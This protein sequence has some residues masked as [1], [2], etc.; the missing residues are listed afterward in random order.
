[1][2]KISNLLTFIST[3][4]L[5]LYSHNINAQEGNYNFEQYGNQSSLLSGNVI[6]GVS[7]LAI[8]YYN[9]S[10]LVFNTQYN[11]LI[12]VKAYELNNFDYKYVF[13]GDRSAS[14]SQFRG[15]PSIVVGNFKFKSLPNHSFAYSFLSRHRSDL[16]LSFST[17]VLDSDVTSDIEGFEQVALDLD[18]SD[19]LTEEWIGLTWAHQPSK[20][21]S[22]GASAFLSIYNLRSSGDFLFSGLQSNDD[23]LV[24]TEKIR[25]KQQTYGLFFKLGATWVN[26]NLKI[27][28]TITLPHI[29]VIKKAEISTQGFFSGSINDSGEITQLSDDDIE[30]KRKT[31][32]GIEGGIEYTLGK[33]KLFGKLQWFLALGEYE[34]LSLS[35]Q[36]INDKLAQ[37][38]F[39][40][41]YKSVFNF[42]VGAEIHINERL[43]LLLSF[44]SDFNAHEKSVSIINEFVSDQAN[45]NI[46]N[47]FWHFGIGTD[48]NISWGSIVLGGTYASSRVN[49]P[50]DDSQNISVL[51]P[52]IEGVLSEIRYQRLRF[53]VG[54]ELPIFEKTIKQLKRSLSN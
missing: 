1:M 33:H 30:N 20:N 5:I 25:F 46:F 36:F 34:R 51:N 26:E 28:T 6:A 29:A 14:S 27:G 43:R 13:G 42:G 4:L 17:G 54:I 23:V 9:P 31:A 49:I 50:Q 48:F 7:D 24:G 40:E 18:I 47:D 39:N 53:I 32:F 45:I 15:L 11:F 44:S 38:H 35:E 16:N 10:S 19:K 2:F 8:T 37:T 3:G 52:D 12:N 22:I 21:W 41:Q